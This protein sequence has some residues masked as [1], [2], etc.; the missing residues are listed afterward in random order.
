MSGNIP[1]PLPITKQQTEA[2]QSSNKWGWQL[3][4]GVLLVKKWFSCF[5]AYQ[6]E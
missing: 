3:L 4:S 6:V 2:K 1:A 5:R